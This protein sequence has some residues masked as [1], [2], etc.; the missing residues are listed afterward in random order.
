MNNSTE[1]FLQANRRNLQ[2][3]MKKYE[4]CPSDM[5]AGQ[6]IREIKKDLLGKLIHFQKKGIYVELV[7]LEMVEFET[8]SGE[9]YW[10]AVPTWGTYLAPWG[11]DN[12]KRVAAGEYM[13]A[14]GEETKKEMIRVANLPII[15]CE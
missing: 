3:K 14:G 12:C 5:K 15:E 8:V 10:R 1:M 7:G 4:I 2:N 9:K 6:A 13:P 11:L